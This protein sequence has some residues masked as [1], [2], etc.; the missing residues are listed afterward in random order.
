MEVLE[1]KKL[2]SVW[3]ES[4]NAKIRSYLSTSEKFGVDFPLKNVLVPFT[5]EVRIEVR[6][7]R[8][9]ARGGKQVHASV[10]L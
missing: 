5:I 8:Q 6:P 1:V 4:Q 7:D 9:H 2:V 3:N 10:C